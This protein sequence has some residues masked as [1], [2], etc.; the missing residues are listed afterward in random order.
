MLNSRNLRPTALAMTI[1]LSVSGCATVDHQLGGMDKTSACVAGGL[2]GA[3]LGAGAAVAMGK[4]AAGG[5][6]VG[7]AAGCGATLVYQ[8]RVKRLQAIAAEEGMTMQVRQLETTQAPAPGK[9]A[10]EIQAV[11]IEAQVQDS[12]MFATGSAVLT[13]D[14]ERQLRKLAAALADS[15]GGTQT[16]QKKILVVGHTDSTGN[17]ELNQKL[18]EQRARAVSTILAQAGLQPAD[19][20]Y[21]GAGASRPVAA[22]ST[23]EGRAQNRRVELTQVDSQQLLVARVRAE[24]NNPKYLE[25]GTRTSPTTPTANA[26]STSG[27]ATEIAKAEK[28]ESTPDTVQ[29]TH[30]VGIAVPGKGGIDF[31][32]HQVVSLDSAMTRGIEPK[33]SVFNIISPAYASAPVGSCVADMPRMSGEVKNLATDRALVDI[34]TT[35]YLPGMNGHP[36]GQAVNGHVAMVGPVSILKDD[37]AVAV[38]PFMQFITDY[39]TTKKQSEKFQ[40]MANTFDGETKVLYRV[41]AVD[42]SK[43]PVSCMDIVFDK[44]SGAATAGE[45]FYPKQGEAYVAEF[46]PLRR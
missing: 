5:A 39:K 1:A 21:Q 38:Q 34:A 4:N 8:A 9:T 43:S 17:A 27:T 30:S 24:R 25:H 37:A 20:Y 22:N 45:L 28:A 41:F 10:S 3:V 16:P 42:P 26:P 15:Q 12:A 32:G 46:A 14:G 7:A 13:A 18:S 11:G 35:D 31:G 6:L 29:A 2:L 19:I 44:R 23:V 36:W 33:K 40:S